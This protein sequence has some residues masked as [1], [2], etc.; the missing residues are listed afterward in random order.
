MRPPHIVLLGGGGVPS[1]DMPL[2]S[3][4]ISSGTLTCRALEWLKEAE[5]LTTDMHDRVEATHERLGAVALVL[6]TEGAIKE[7]LS[8]SGNTSTN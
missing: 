1:P 4:T 3:W 5:A 7:T 6:M 8:V 2:Q